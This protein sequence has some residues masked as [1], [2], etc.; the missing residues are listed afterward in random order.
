MIPDDVSERSFVN[1]DLIGN[2]IRDFSKND[3]VNWGNLESNSA[4]E[5]AG[6][7]D[8]KKKSKGKGKNRVKTKQDQKEVEQRKI[9]KA[10]VKRQERLALEDDC[11]G[12]GEGELQTEA[13]NNMIQD[14]DVNDDFDDFD[15]EASNAPS[16]R[17]SNLV[18]KS[19]SVQYS[20]QLSP[21]HGD[22]F[23]GFDEVQIEKPQEVKAAL[24]LLEIPTKASQFDRDMRG[25]KDQLDEQRDYLRRI[26]PE[27]L[28]LIF[29][30]SI[31]VENILGMVTA[32]NGASEKWLTTNAEYLG[33][34][35]N[36]LTQ[37]DRFGIV[38]SSL[39]ENERSEVSELFSKLDGS[40]SSVQK[41][42]EGGLWH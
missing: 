22:S 41:L 13:R 35:L 5:K 34:F 3:R 18:Q 20:D 1:F 7:K 21:F 19:N 23:F 32:F 39:D 9:E 33:N 15:Q 14:L 27:N 42:K 8:K 4:Y 16:T 36:N 24:I 38:A 40:I 28:K 10:R 37:V 26:D 29:K 17:K 31:E 12:E 25:M 2:E 11:E 30:S 6:G